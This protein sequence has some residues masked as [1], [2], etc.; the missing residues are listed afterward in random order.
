[1]NADEKARRRSAP[2]RE[3]VPLSA[4]IDLEFGE[5]QRIRILVPPDD[6]KEAHADIVTIWGQRIAGLQHVLD[7]ADQ[8]DDQQLTSAIAAT[9]A[10]ARHLNEI[11]R[12]IGVGECTL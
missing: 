9:D 7:T 11:F 4:V 3:T 2:D 6:L 5:L 1:L 8:M 12:Q 10:L